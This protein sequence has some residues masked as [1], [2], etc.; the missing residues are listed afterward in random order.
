ML[1]VETFEGLCLPVMG[2]LGCWKW[3]TL[4]IE[5]HPAIKV[6]CIRGNQV[7]TNFRP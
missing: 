1:Y 6:H 3:E 5:F 7:I 2:S 4:Q